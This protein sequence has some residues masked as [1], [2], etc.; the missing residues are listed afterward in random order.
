MNSS[1]YTFEELK[2]IYRKH[3]TLGYLGVDINTKFALISLVN[4]IT[5]KIKDKKP[6]VTHYRVLRSIIG[7]Q[8]LDEH[9]QGLAIVCEDF[10]YQCTE[11]PTFDIPDKEIPNKIKEILLNWL[12]F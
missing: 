8:I 5:R 9:I 12:P 2:D 3:F 1:K 7:D 11:Y 6:D 4:Y 10:S